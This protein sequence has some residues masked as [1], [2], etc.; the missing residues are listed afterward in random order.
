MADCY[1]DI[2]QCDATVVIR[3]LAAAVSLLGTVTGLVSG[4]LLIINRGKTNRAQLAARS[5]KHPR[6]L[7]YPEGTRRPH[8][9]TPAPLRP[10]GLKN[11]YEA[12]HPVRI[13]MT[14][15]KVTSPYPW[16]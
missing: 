11:A 5:A 9:T 1:V 8:S 7:L 12:G 10:G 16:P 3:Q 6:L 14:A 2:W 13:V 4:R 15:G